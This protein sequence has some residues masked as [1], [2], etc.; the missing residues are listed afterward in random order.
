[1]AITFV[2]YNYMHWYTSNARDRKVTDPRDMRTTTDDKLAIC[3]KSF[4]QMS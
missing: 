1:M 2:K 3:V 4:L